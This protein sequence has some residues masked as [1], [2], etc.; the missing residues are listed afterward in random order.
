MKWFLD[1]EYECAEVGAHLPI[2][3]ALLQPELTK[4]NKS[5]GGGGHIFLNF[6]LKKLKLR[7]NIFF[8]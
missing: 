2:A 4:I 6:L 5:E 7:K 1:D 3:H 8:N